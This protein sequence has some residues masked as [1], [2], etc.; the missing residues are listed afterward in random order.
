MADKNESGIFKVAM[1]LILTCLVSGCIIGVVYAATGKIAYE[2][3]EQMKQDSMKSLV[4]Q[5][6]KFDPVPGEKDTF[7]AEQ[8]GSGLYHSDG[9]ERLRRRYQDADGCF[10]GWHGYGLHGPRSQRN[11]GP[12][13]QRC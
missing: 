4:P 1:N 7:V 10:H 5:A 2:K 11:S 6:E 9:S 8:G 13:R 12:R 3:A